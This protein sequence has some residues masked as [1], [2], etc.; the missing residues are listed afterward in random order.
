MVWLPLGPA[1]PSPSL[2]PLISSQDSITYR[3]TLNQSEEQVTLFSRLPLSA[4]QIVLLFTSLR[5]PQHSIALCRGPGTSFVLVSGVPAF[6]SFLPQYEG[7]NFSA[8]PS[9]VYEG[10]S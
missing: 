3:C 10:Q 5:L 8:P 6:H 1:K 2:T 9:S 7:E 4:L